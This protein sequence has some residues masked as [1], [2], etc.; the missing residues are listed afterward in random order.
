MQHDAIETTNVA[1]EE[2]GWS[3]TAADA[4]VAATRGQSLTAAASAE[5]NRLLRQLP[6]SERRIG[7]KMTGTKKRMRI[8]C[9]FSIYKAGYMM[10]LGLH[11]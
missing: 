10:Y 2:E 5:A 11:A 8:L 6:L 9:R 4:A 1:D 7:S 3:R